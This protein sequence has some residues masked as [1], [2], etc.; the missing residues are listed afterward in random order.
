MKPRRRYHIASAQYQQ[1]PAASRARCIRSV[2]PRVMAAARP[3]DH[4]RHERSVMPTMRTMK[5]QQQRQVDITH[6]PYA[7]PREARYAE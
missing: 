1:M 3:P 6:T 4:P 5:T 2:H 7:A